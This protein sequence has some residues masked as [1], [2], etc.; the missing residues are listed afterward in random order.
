MLKFFRKIRYDLMEKNKTGRYLKYAIGEVVLVVIGI[1]IAF[2]VNNWNENRKAEEK[3]NNLFHNLSI[4]FES[5]LIELKEFNV[6][7][8]E[9]INAIL[10]LNT[11][12]ANPSKRPKEVLLD[13]L[14]SKTLLGFKFNEEFKML[15]VVFNTGLIN[16]I[17]NEKLKRQ[18]I[19][20]PQKIEEML[21]EQRMHN[22]L[23]EDQLVSIIM[24][25]VSLRSIYEQMDFR[26]YNLPK[27][28]PV[29]LQKNYDGL[30]SDPLF[31]N[32][33]AMSEML[34]RITKIDIGVLISSA[35]AIIVLLKDKV[36]ID[37]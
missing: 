23:L 18:L 8:T 37:N 11:I 10:A 29:T 22:R 35:E 16:D 30:L 28:E 12:I 7:K 2:Q 36:E 1:L 33:L 32:Y 31:E 17:K 13:S 19:E 20:W 14:L 27:G 15:D 9:S 26:Q 25:Y 21:E 24:R 6:G 4:D 34:I 5:R 3:Q